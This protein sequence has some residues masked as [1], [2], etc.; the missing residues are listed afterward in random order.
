MLS[1]KLLPG[2][3]QNGKAFLSSRY[4]VYRWLTSICKNSTCSFLLKDVYSLQLFT[5]RHRLSKLAN[6]DT[7]APSCAVVGVSPPKNTKPICSQLFCMCVCPFLLPH[8]PN[9]FPKTTGKS[10]RQLSDQ[11]GMDRN[12]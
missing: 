9:Q 2:Q 11:N 8:Y 1:L 6:K 7:E 5:H 10:S 4:E 12:N 3:A